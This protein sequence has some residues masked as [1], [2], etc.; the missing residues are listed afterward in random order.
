MKCDDR[1][2]YLVGGYFGVKAMESYSRR[3]FILK[4]IEEY[5]RKY[6]RYSEEKLDYKEIA[7]SVE[8]ATG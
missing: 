6:V 8:K 7:S 2:K 3:L 1:F 4:E 5:I